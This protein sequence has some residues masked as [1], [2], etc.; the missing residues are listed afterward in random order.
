MARI[1]ECDICG[2]EMA[3]DEVHPFVDI[4]ENASTLRINFTNRDN[5]DM[6]GDK[7]LLFEICPHCTQRVMDFIK[8]LTNE[9][10][11]GDEN[12]SHGVSY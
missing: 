5:H 7:D 6:L 9:G 12:S 10:R 4:P 11:F 1:I 8:N 3:R 2:G